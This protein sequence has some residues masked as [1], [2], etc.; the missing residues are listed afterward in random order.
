MQLR[1]YGRAW[2][3]Q[4][5]PPRDQ[6]RA[7]TVRERIAPPAGVR[8]GSTRASP[9]LPLADARGSDSNWVRAATVRER[10]VPLADTRTLAA[11]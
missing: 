5:H 1:P 4:I 8:L 9:T 11:G 10:Y 7:A 6:I 2:L 3:G